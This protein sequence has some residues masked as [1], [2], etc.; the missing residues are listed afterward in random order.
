MAHEH[1]AKLMAELVSEL[2]PLAVLGS[3]VHFVGRIAQSSEEGPGRLTRQV[4]DADRFVKRISQL[5]QDVRGDVLQ[6]FLDIVATRNAPVAF[7]YFKFH[8]TTKQP[9][10]VT[11]QVTLFRIAMKAVWDVAHRA[12]AIRVGLVLVP[13]L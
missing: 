7:E 4:Q 10:G 9:V 8:D 1:V 13:V 12:S 2:T 3:E 11:A 6:Q 5:A